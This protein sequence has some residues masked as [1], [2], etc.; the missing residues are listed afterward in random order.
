MLLNVHGGERAGLILGAAVDGDVQR[1]LAG[2]INLSLE[3]ATNRILDHGEIM[4]ESPDFY[5]HVRHACMN[6]ITVVLN[7]FVGG[8]KQQHKGWT[9]VVCLRCPRKRKPVLYRK[10]PRVGCM[11]KDRDR[12]CVRPL[13]IY[14]RQRITEPKIIQ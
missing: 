10:S 5:F 14:T 2:P 7:I 8:T 6:T 11:Q 12:I 1:S 13:L 4:V 3:Q 9:N